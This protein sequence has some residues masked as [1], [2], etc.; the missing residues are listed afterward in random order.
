M[1]VCVVAPYKP[2]ISETFIRGHVERMPARAMLVYGWPLVEDGRPVLSTARRFY[3]KV[4]R[5]L[6]RAGVEREYTDAYMTAFR[7]ARTRVVLAEY[8]DVGVQVEEACRRLGVPFVVHFHGYD[9]SVR[10]VLEE[11]RES[12]PR[13]FHEAAAVIAVSRAM[14][15]K[16][17]SLGAPAGK[18]HYNPCGIDCDMF[19]GAA[20]AQAPPVFLAV[21]RFVEKK[22]PQLTL[23][24]FAEVWRAQT[25]ARLRML[26]D[27]PLL[28]KCRALAR[29]LGLDGA[30]EFL[31]AQS[32]ERVQEEM[33]RARCFVQHSIEAPNGD[34]EG[35][36]VGILEAGA[37]GL[38][39]VATRH[40]GIPDVVVDGET[41]LLVE[42]KD[43]RGMAAHML[44]LAR[45]PALAGALGEKARRHIAENFSIEQSDRRLWAIIEACA[46][47]PSPAGPGNV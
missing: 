31:G 12:Y 43:V 29:E 17:I 19:G 46:G 40:A 15:R 41:G 27:G 36:P 28:E 4:L 8:G 5:K 42:E 21:G 44:A 11:H 13:M 35:T 38:P 32:H 22:A 26:G 47:K 10:E 24:A 45:D 14:Q 16:L 37:S 6:F 23:M 20:P 25:D 34:C 3:H 18:V 7:R 9:A 33:R 2:S 39:V 30:V 1:R